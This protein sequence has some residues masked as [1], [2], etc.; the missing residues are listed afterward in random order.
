MTSLYRLTTSPRWSTLFWRDGAQHSREF[1]VARSS[2]AKIPGVREHPKALDVPVTAL[3]LPEVR[4]VLELAEVE[5]PIVPGTSFFENIEN[6]ALWTADRK[7]FGHQCDGARFIVNAGS[8]LVCDEMGVGKTT[9]AIIAA[10]THRAESGGPGV[11]VAPKFTRATWLRELLLTGA[12]DSAEEFCTLESRNLDDTSWRAG[13]KWYFMHYDVV[14][15]WWTRL[16]TYAHPSVA[17]IDEAH[18]IKN[19]K[20]KRAKG[21]E[22]VAGPTKMRILLTGT[23]LVN[24]PADLW[25]PLQC[26]TGSG[27]WG[28]PLDFRIRYNGAVRT[29]WGHE[30]LGP[31]HVEE[32]RTRMAPWYIRRTAQDAGL[33]LPELTRSVVEVDMLPAFV[34][35]HHACFRN[36]DPAAILEALLENRMGEQTLRMLHRLRQLTSAA[37]GNATAEFVNNLL[38]QDEACVVFC[39]QP[40]TAHALCAATRD[41]AWAGVVSGNENQTTRDSLIESFQDGKGP[42]ALFC[43]YGTVREGVTLHRARHVIHHDLDWVATTIQQSEKRIHRIGQPRACTATWMVARNSMDVIFA[44]VLQTKLD[45]A[46]Q[47]FGAANPFEAML[48]SISPSMSLEEKMRAAIDEWRAW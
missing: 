17:I 48:K 47:V 4:R 25:H 27:T 9:T 37:K 8:A 41:G 35:E 18:W 16:H 10:E 39:W 13:A 36:T 12:I 46:Q 33:S 34:K 42:A 2:A 14:S 44:Q 6:D 7:P 11:I 20:A 21:A 15:V 3:M 23:P 43:T 32:L 19:G 5:L 29:A 45:A 31:T 24:T 22:L 40:A 26:V 28:S 30:D 1:Q 38:E